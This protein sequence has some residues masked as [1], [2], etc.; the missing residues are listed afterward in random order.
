MRDDLASLSDQIN[1]FGA[2]T[3]PPGELP[4]RLQSFTPEHEAAEH[5]EMKKKTMAQLMPLLTVNEKITGFCTD[6]QS[7]VSL[8]IK[9]EDESKTYRLQYPIAHALKPCI[10]KIIDEWRATGK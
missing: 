8:T 9:P 6:P 10:G 3:L 5:E 4:A 7:E 1:S 2:G